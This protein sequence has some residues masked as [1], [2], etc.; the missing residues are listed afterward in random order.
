M[1]LSFLVEDI[2]VK[3]D[4]KTTSQRSDGFRQF[5]SFLLTISAQSSTNQL[6]YSLL[7]L[8]EPETHLHPQAQECLRKE[9]IKITRNKE[10]NI[11]LFATHSNY[12]IDK[13]HIDRCFRV[14]K[15][16]NKK[17]KL[18]RIKGQGSS[19]SEV[20][21]EVFGISTNDYHNELYGYLED[22]EK[23]KLENLPQNKKWYNEKT[24][25]TDGVSLAT[26]IRHSIHHPENTS[27]A[28]FTDNELTESIKSLRKAKYGTE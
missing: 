13:N 20:N 5:I 26:Y 2:G 19:Y 16:G 6:S 27:N 11:I 28:K 25:K 10:N 7:L 24:K 12:M 14:V 15:Q 22:I 3:Y 17:T 18:E 21:Y 4:S 23:T 1:M 9:L 8:D